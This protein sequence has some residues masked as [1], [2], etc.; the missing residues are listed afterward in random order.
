MDR[1]ETCRSFYASLI[2]AN[3]G[4][5][6]GR[7]S[8]AFAAVPRERFAGPGPWRIF[9]PIGYIPT[10]SD[11]PAFLYQDV[12]V[13]LQAEGQINNGQP[14]LHAVCL[15]ALRV[16]P[17]EA[18]VHVGAGSGYYSAVL[19]E[20]AGPG[21]SVVGYE[22]DQGLAERAAANLADR[23]NVEVR[24]RS[25]SEGALPE[26]DVL[27]VSAGATDPMDSWLD[28]LRPG[29]RLLFPLTPAQGPGAMLLVT[30]TPDGLAARFV[31]QAMFIP[32]LGARDEEV[33]RRLAEAFQA[34]GLKDVRSL[35]R[36][37]AP[38]ETCWVFGR[39]WWLST[40]PLQP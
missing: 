35:R 26:C 3:V 5:P 12:T 30:R 27:Y 10:P 19:A 28:A 17:G 36:D 1:L 18:V 11:D 37:A 15:A 31:C 2:T 6:P 20:L 7:L 23:P 8:E 24:N 21:G 22:V 39:G 9:T 38:D 14:T 4:V 34:G 13:A 25:G 32:C 40:A 16:E 33:A 29:G